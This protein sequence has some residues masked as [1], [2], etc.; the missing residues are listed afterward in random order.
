MMTT[1]RMIGIGAVVLPVAL[2]GGRAAAKP[3]AETVHLEVNGGAWTG[4]YEATS[5]GGGCTADEKKG[6]WSNELYVTSALKPNDL[7]NLPLTVP[8]AKAAA[9]GTSEFY[10]GIGFG[11][12]NKRLDATYQIQIE[13]RKDHP[14]DWL[15]SGTVTIEDKG[16]TAVVRFQGTSAR[17]EAIKGTITCNSVT[18]KK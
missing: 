4:T 18:R 3:P 15:G 2:A 17:S 11:P 6:S 8:D 10:L 7:V 9:N 12:L 5:T 1:R 13:T 16:D 14:K